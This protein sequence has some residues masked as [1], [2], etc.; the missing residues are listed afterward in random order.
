MKVS[1]VLACVLAVAAASPSLRHNWSRFKVEHGRHYASVEEERYRLSVFEQNQQ[2][3]DE[4]NAQFENGEVTFTLKM[5]QFGDMTTEE[6]VG[7]MNGFISTPGRRPV[8]TLRA[9]EETLPKEVDWRTK[10]AVTPVKDQK[11]CGSCWAFSTTGSLEGQHF[12]KDGKLVSLS[13]QNLVDCSGKYGNL[14]CFGGLMDNAFRYI[15]ANKGIDTE[16]SYPYEAKNGQ[17][18]FNASDVGATDTGFVDVEHGSESALK[19]AVATIGPIS[20][21]IDASRPTFHFYHDGVYSDKSCSSM[22]LDHGVLAVGYGSAENGGDYWLV[23]NSWNTSWGN[24]GYIQMSRNNENNCGIATQAS[25]PVSV[26]A[27]AAHTLASYKAR[28]AQ[29]PSES[30]K[31][32]FL[33]VLACV[34]AVSVASPSLRQQWHNFKAEHGRHY[35]SVEEERYRLSVF[36]QNQQFIDEHNARFENDEVTFTLKMNQFGDMTSEEFSATMN[37]FLNVPSR[38]PVAI[39]EADDET[40]PEKVDWRTKGAVTPVKDQKQCGSCWAFSTTGSLEGQHFLKD[41]KLVS[42]SEQNLVDCSG[43]FGNMGCGGGLMDQAFRYI[44]ANKGIDTEASYPYEAQDGKCRFDSS[45]V[46]ATDTGFVDVEHGSESALQKAVAKVGPISVAIDAS[47]PSFQFYHNGVYYEEQCSST[48]LDHGVLAVGYG[49]EE[50]GGDYWLV[51]NSWNTSWGNKGYIQM[52]R[53]KKNN[54]GIASQASYPL[55]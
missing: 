53:N 3:I 22:H 36:E 27:V 31:M 11:Q 4:H 24:K 9:D 26:G 19:K 40:L 34:V 6:I 46:G 5:N 35:A 55:V 15:K 1:A 47:Q 39:L 28:C 54:C 7:A 2:F 32:K 29:V 51:K 44:K 52:S 23:K 17:C 49:S 25:Y 21:A 41:G 12:L 43:K 20:V 33:S 50:K 14:G 13:E 18:R 8:A 38:R 37:G 45:N 48:M 16:E 30:V 42:L 10:G